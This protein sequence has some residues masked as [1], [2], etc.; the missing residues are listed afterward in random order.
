MLQFLKELLWLVIALIIA[1][2]VQLPIISEIEYKYVIANTLMIFISVYYFRTVLDFKNMF[3]FKLKWVKYFLFALNLFLF[4][5]I[6]TR[7]QKILLFFEL[8]TISSYSK[9]VN[10]LSSEK[11]VFLLNYIQKEYLFFSL[12]ALLII[13]VLNTKII[14][15]F[16][17]NEPKF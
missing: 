3:F 8:F 6:V 12:F 2:L 15:S 7:I 11:E 1:V 10:I 4:V 9:S 13:V 5:F 14:A 17:N 16:W